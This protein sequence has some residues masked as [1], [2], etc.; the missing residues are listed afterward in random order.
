MARKYL[1]LEQ[2]LKTVTNNTNKFMERKLFCPEYDATEKMK[3][4]RYSV[5]LRI[6]IP[7]FILVLGVRQLQI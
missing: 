1:A 6:L 4:C 5:M 2:T 3:I 7:A